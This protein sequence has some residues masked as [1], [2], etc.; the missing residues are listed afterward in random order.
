MWGDRSEDSKFSSIWL[1][2]I[3]ETYKYAVILNL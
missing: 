2:Y 1:S 3:I